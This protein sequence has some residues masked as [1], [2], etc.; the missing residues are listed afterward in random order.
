MSAEA[1]VIF[2][3]TIPFAH[4][5]IFYRWLERRL[6]LGQCDVTVKHTS[7]GDADHRIHCHSETQYRRESSIMGHENWCCGGENEPH[8]SAQPGAWPGHG[9]RCPEPARPPLSIRDDGNHQTGLFQEP[10]VMAQSLYQKSSQSESWFNFTLGIT[11]ELESALAC[12]QAVVLIPLLWISH[13]LSTENPVSFSWKSYWFY[14]GGY[15][16]F[17]LWILVGIQCI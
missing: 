17:T 15:C 16:V 5:F 9:L 6:S 14:S 1:L 3:R 12:I 8:T 4:S 2:L 7:C 10:K 11:E 13:G